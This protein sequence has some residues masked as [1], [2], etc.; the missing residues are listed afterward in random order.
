[1]G[2]ARNIQFYRNGTV[3]PITDAVA[4][5]LKSAYKQAEQAFITTG[6]HNDML[7]G[8][9]LLYRFSYKNIVHTLVGVVHVN[10]EVKSLE[11]LANYDMLGTEISNEISTAIAKLDGSAQIASVDEG[12]VTLKAGIV[13]TDGIVSQGTGEDIT[14]AKVATTGAAADVSIADTDNVIEATTVEGALL[15]IAKEI[16]NMDLTAAHVV[17]LSTNKDALQARKIS[18]T[19]GKITLGSPESFVEFNQALSET[20]KVATMKDVAAVQS[21]ATVSGKEAIVVE[22]ATGEGATGKVVSLKIADNEKVLSQ[23][24]KGLSSTISLSYDS[25]NKLIKL[26]GIQDNVISSFS[27][28]DFIKDGMLKSAE[29]VTLSAGE[30]GEGKP[31]G[32]YIKL[33]FNQDGPADPI[34]INVTELV[35]VYTAKATEGNYERK[36]IDIDGSNVISHALTGDIT[37]TTN[38]S[39]DINLSSTSSQ[40]ITITNYSFDN[41]GHIESKENT[42]YNLNIQ[43]TDNILTTID[44]KGSQG[45]VYQGN[46]TNTEKPEIAL[47]V[48][49]IIDFYGWGTLT[50]CGH[51]YIEKV[52]YNNNFQLQDDWPVYRYKGQQV[53]YTSET[54]IVDDTTPQSIAYMHHLP[55]NRKLSV[56]TSEKELERCINLLQQYENT[57]GMFHQMDYITPDGD[58][59]TEGIC[60]WRI[61][62]VDQVLDFG[63]DLVSSTAV[64]DALG[65]VKEITFEQIKSL[66]LKLNRN[67]RGDDVINITTENNTVEFKHKTS[68]VS[69]DGNN[70]TKGDVTGTTIKVPVITVNKYGHVTALTE[71]EYTVT[72]PTSSV[73]AGNGLALSS[74]TNGTNTEYTVEVKLNENTN[75]MLTVDANGLNLNSTW[76]C[77]VY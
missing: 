13:Q 56:I 10:E 55:D 70:I 69:E 27:T 3:T 1:M 60:V 54:T 71:E 31:A 34:Y 75:D 26:L 2:I 51:V 39:Q 33:T 9:I 24:V 30:A 47:Q 61:A 11:V 76:D 59:I 41:A 66:D 73:V 35:D 67:Y 53:G 25:T 8:E 50:E 64:G 43:K 18:E 32:K 48:G 21:N 12:V 15:E 72:Y 38:E 17:G 44:L 63:D 4:T 7:D 65:E 74:E 52:L 28:N 77:G 5:D 40:N 6:K 58:T 45:W 62:D 42:T 16:D 37:T 36:Y 23:G 14:L 49:D 19:D 20:N 22:N 68:G 46:I 29:L 57:H